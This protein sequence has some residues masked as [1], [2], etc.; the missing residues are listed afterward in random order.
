MSGLLGSDQLG[1]MLT[2]FTHSNSIFSRDFTC[3]GKINSWLI[4]GVPGEP[5]GNQ[6][7]LNHFRNTQDGGIS[8]V[9]Y[10][11]IGISDIVPTDSPNVYRINTTLSQFELESGDRII[12]TYDTTS[13]STDQFTI[14]II[15][16]EMADEV[17]NIQ[18]SSSFALDFP[19]LSIEM[20]SKSATF[21]YLM[22]HCVIPS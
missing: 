4:G 14:N 17:N 10:T 11:T 22:P 12:I 3:S 8:L 9:A 16:V 2:K 15:D 6:F 19:L 5:D 13:A 7:T 21:N 18:I 1:N 20:S